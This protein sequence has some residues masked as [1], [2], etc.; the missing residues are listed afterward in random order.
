MYIDIKEI[1]KLNEAYFKII[2]NILMYKAYFHYIQKYI[3]LMKKLIK[4]NVKDEEN[5]KKAISLLLHQKNVLITDSENIEKSYKIHKDLINH[6]TI[7][8]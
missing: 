5:Y 6:V 4:E 7:I 8:Y 3:L 2:K 1:N